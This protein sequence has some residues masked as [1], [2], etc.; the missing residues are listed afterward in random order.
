[1]LI[2]SYISFLFLVHTIPG[3]DYNTPRTVAGLKTG[4]F[5]T[6]WIEYCDRAAPQMMMILYTLIDRTP[7]LFT[8]ITHG[9][10]RVS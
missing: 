2:S 9:I 7:K 10:Y 5:Q 8:I 1:M 4:I 3:P 6:A